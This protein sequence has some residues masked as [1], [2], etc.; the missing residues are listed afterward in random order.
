MVLTI[1]AQKSENRYGFYR[2]GYGFERP[3]LKKVTGK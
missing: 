1:L 3:G 2:N